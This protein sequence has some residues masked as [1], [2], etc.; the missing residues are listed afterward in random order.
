MRSVGL[1]VGFNVGDK[2]GLTVEC[3]EG[4]DDGMFEKEGCSD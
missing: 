4:F 1:F 3:F 2:V